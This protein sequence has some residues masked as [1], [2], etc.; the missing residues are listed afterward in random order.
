MVVEVAGPEV[1]EPE[2]PEPEVRSARA[3][4]RWV[5][6]STRLGAGVV[7]ASLPLIIYLGIAVTGWAWP[8]LIA[9]LFAL[10]VFFAPSWLVDSPVLDSIPGI[11]SAIEGRRW[12]D[13]RERVDELLS[14]YH[15][16]LADAGLEMSGVSADRLPVVPTSTPDEMLTAQLIDLATAAVQRSNGAIE[17]APCRSFAVLAGGEY[18]R[19]R[20]PYRSEA[21]KSLSLEGFEGGADFAELVVAYYEAGKEHESDEPEQRGLGDLVAAGRADPVGRWPREIDRVR[22]HLN[23]REWPPRYGALQ[24]ESF[25][26]AAAEHHKVAELTDNAAVVRS[27]RRL[28]GKVSLDTYRRFLDTQRL[29]G[30]LVNFDCSRGGVADLLEG[31]KTGF[32]GGT[33]YNYVQYTHSTRIGVVPR[34]TTFEDFAEQFR[35]DFATV[36]AEAR[37]EEDRREVPFSKRLAGV[38]VALQRFQLSK[39][40]TVVAEADRAVEHLQE[41]I[42]DA[43][44]PEERAALLGYD[45]AT[46]TVNILD[47]VLELSLVEAAADLDLDGCQ[48]KLNAADAHVRAELLTR[49]NYA[50]RRDLAIACA[51]DAT[52]AART[53]GDLSQMV[54]T[55]SGGA[56]DGP[57]ADS[58]SKAY[59][60]AFVTVGRVF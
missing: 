21:L 54:L 37:A 55:A 13:A 8:L 18:L 30:Y 47:G 45:K 38:E 16:F 48:T 22:N 29:V 3:T 32:G 17:K 25:D 23:R 35:E 52:V 27:L 50:T 56:I 14:D 57:L 31:Q 41:V 53:Q 36:L 49:S 12:V 58:I 5:R 60:D 6:W 4:P 33:T 26:Q 9:P 11:H 39:Y 2:V 34:D 19:L 46:T 51:D 7:F 40:Y 28:L 15:S 59:V 20:A 1:A 43:F 10:L 44:T 42:V 24:G